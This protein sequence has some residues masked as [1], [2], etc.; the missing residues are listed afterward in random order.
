MP[1]ERERVQCSYSA[2]QTHL[3]M[4]HTHKTGMI[5]YLAIK[6]NEHMTITFYYI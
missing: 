6:Q 2:G 4:A 3:G 1:A 5:K